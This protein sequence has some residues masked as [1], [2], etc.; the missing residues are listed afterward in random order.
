MLFQL[1][2]IVIFHA[3]DGSGYEFLT[4]MLLQLDAFN[5]QIAA[6]IAVPTQPMATARCAQD[7]H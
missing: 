4:D 3:I 7:K 1:I 2:T 5:P 6:R